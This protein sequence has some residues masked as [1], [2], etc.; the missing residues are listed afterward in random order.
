MCQK[1]ALLATAGHENGRDK[2]GHSGFF[3]RAAQNTKS[4]AASDV[5]PERSTL[6]RPTVSKAPPLV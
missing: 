2:P 6:L 5:T 1:T 4:V 3:G